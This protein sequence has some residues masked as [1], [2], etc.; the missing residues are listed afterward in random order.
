MACCH[1]SGEWCSG[2]GP[3]ANDRMVEEHA[4]LRAENERLRAFV[5]R[6]SDGPCEL[7]CQTREN[8]D[9]DPRVPSACTACSASRELKG[10]DDD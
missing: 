6:V 3:A 8:C 7:A 4:T 5:T 10:T 1:F 2:C 9:D